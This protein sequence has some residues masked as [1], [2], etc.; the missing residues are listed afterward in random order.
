MMD[1]NTAAAGKVEACYECQA[2]VKDNDYMILWQL[3]APLP[4][5]K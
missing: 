3:D 5:K 2:G 4:E 1:G